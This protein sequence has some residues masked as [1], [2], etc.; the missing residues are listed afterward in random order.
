MNAP[1]VI[2]EIPYR[3]PLD[4]FA[5]FAERPFCAFLDCPDGTG[6]HAYIAPEPAAIIAPDRSGDSLGD[7][8]TG[9][10]R[11][12][13]ATSGGRAIGDAVMNSGLPPF[14]GGIIGY[15][16][17][18]LGRHLERLPRPHDAGTD[19]PE[20]IAGLYDTV[21]A[22]DCRSRR[23]WVIA[24][25][26]KQD[27]EQDWTGAGGT[28]RPPAG[29]RG[30]ALAE[31]IAAAPALGPAPLP[32]APSRRPARAGWQA[33][34][35]RTDYEARV[36]RIIDYIRAGDI[37]QANL[38]QRFLAPKPAGLHP[39]A[40]YRRLR[41]ASPAPY[42][43][44][45]GCGE[46]RAVLSASP[47][48][49]LT[50]DET[51]TVVTQPIKGSRPRSADEAED[52]RLAAALEASTKDK[53]ENLMIVDLLR[54][55]LSRVCRVGSVK[56]PVLHRLESFA[57]MHHLVSTVSGRLRPEATAVDLLKACFPGGSVT[58]APKIRAMEIIHEL[59]PARRGP[60]CGALGWIGTDGR[61]ETS[62]VIRSLVV[63]G[64]TV[65]AQAGGAIVADS[66]PAAEYD[67]SLSKAR[68][69]LGCLNPD[70]WDAA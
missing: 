33:E 23:A 37:F 49:F 17:Y 40:L 70:A 15:F 69:L 30:R 38:T 66:D 6:H 31:A 1:P 53:A 14:R 27:W 63:D 13:A 55:D 41:A 34:I 29:A 9:L 25:D 24:Q 45:L 57:S 47:E 36:A 60:Y 68:A 59:E 48:M 61:M 46:G 20:M 22:F 12:L 32:S 28:T 58:G 50:V 19:L 54:N 5:P 35:A 67:E 16:G 52:S 65:I 43:A 7:G 4:A 11:A 44:Y 26:W 64:T 51:G 10:E 56:V 8:W 21:A 39:F 2:L 3:D 42:A 18:E 62:I